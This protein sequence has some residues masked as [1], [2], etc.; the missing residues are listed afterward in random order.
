M[1]HVPVGHGLRRGY[2]VRHVMLLTSLC[3]QASH[4]NPNL[5]KG[6][7][8]CVAGLGIQFLYSIDLEP[9]VRGI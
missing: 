1:A 7:T 4:P 9:S 6:S 2:C 3:S 5:E 8:R